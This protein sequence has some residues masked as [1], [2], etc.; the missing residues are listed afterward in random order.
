[1]TRK[2]VRVLVMAMALFATR[3]VSAAVITPTDFDSWLT[4]ADALILGPSLPDPFDPAPPETNP[5]GSL[6]NSVYFDSGT[7][8]YTYVHEVTPAQNNVM[9]F[10]TGFGVSGFTGTAG[11]SFSE[12]DGVNGCGGPATCGNVF[13]DFI[14]QG[15]AGAQINWMAFDDLFNDWDAGET[16]TFFF[17]STLAPREGGNYNLTATSTGT[18]QSAAPIPEP[19]SIALLGSGLVVLYGAAR[20]RRNAKHQV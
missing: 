17:V 8:E 5:V 13:G 9:F 12:S 14:V 20:R 18:A 2:F 4:G 11:W 10:N 7:L 3:E 15:G 19:G 6:I 16:I 1:M